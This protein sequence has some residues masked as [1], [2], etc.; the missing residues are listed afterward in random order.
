MESTQPLTA[1]QLQSARQNTA[2]A[3][4][5]AKTHHHDHAVQFYDDDSFLGTVVSEFLAGALREG[6]PVVVIASANHR[7]AF[8]ARLRAAGFDL[9]AARKRHQFVMLDARATLRQFM[10]GNTPDPVRFRNL[11]GRVI[12]RCVAKVPAVRVRAYGEMV[13]LLWK[14]GNTEGAVR[15]EELWNELARSYDFSLLCAYSM[16]NF[17]RSTDADLFRRICSEHTRVTPTETLNL[18][19]DRER[20]IQTSLL[21]QR[22]R[23]L[24]AEI[25]QRELLE[26]RLRETVV[27]VQE[28][29]LDIKDVLENAA[30]G[31][32]LVTGT[33]MIQWANDA[34]LSM[35]GYSAEEYVG[36]PI[37]NFHVHR[38][39]IDDMLARLSRGETLRDYEARLRHKDGS[40]RYV[41]VNSNV[42]WKDGEF[43]HTRCFSRDITLVRQAS[44]EREQLLE[45]ER[46]ARLD[47]E[48]AREE[49]DRARLVAEQANRAKSDFLAI[50]SHE[51]RT[52]LN[53]IGG[54]AELMELGIH[55]PVN[56]AQREALDRIQRSQRMLL[57]LI[58][59]VL[60]YARIETGNVHYDVVKVP[61]DE[62]VRAIEAL[63]MPQ[64][65]SK[66][67]RYEYAGCASAVAVRA[68][69]E[70]LQQIL[71]NLLANAI[72]FTDRGG[73]IT[74]DVE[75]VGLDVFIHMRDTGVGIPSE[76][77]HLIFEPFVQVDSNYNRKRDGA[78]LGLAISRDLARGMDGELTVASTLGEGSTFTLKLPRAPA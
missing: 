53:A 26:Q 76:K 47:A 55:G 43:V 40:I 69:G 62:T 16:G 65:R 28:R 45:R 22:A 74:I 50:M 63:L 52:P 36:Q 32:H 58:N 24:E 56:E 67:L 39:V 34:E 1:A 68:D 64:M 33:G 78:G 38:D 18:A 15:L 66:A 61:V 6:Q 3:L 48:R 2:A 57:G 42:R 70:K 37:A 29:E 27:A 60:N 54:H 20:L 4:P 23:S 51:L 11:I 10:V 30:E 46:A 12:E 72:K 31:I 44:L 19:D 49:A 35:L 9:G 5:P 73:Q 71:I 7:K 41:L 8:L 13:D 25:A 17:C 14:D 21:E 75:D 77:L 59:Q